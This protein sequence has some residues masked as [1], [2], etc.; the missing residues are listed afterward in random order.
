MYSKLIKL[1]EN[2]SEKM[3]IIENIFKNITIEERMV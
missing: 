1:V 2:N 3:N